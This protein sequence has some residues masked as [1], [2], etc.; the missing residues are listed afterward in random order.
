MANIEAAVKKQARQRRKG[1]PSISKEDLLG[2]VTRNVKRSLMLHFQSFYYFYI[3]DI[4]AD[5]FIWAVLTDIRDLLDDAEFENA[6]RQACREF[7]SRLNL[8][9]GSEVDQMIER[10]FVLGT[11]E[12]RH[13]AGGAIA[14]IGDG[15]PSPEGEKLLRELYASVDSESLLP[16]EIQARMTRI[17]KGV[18]P[19]HKY[20][21]FNFSV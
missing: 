21:L 5:D 7:R 17:T 18:D 19:A 11:E 8:G 16:P 1:S 14:R 3:P 4:E 10:I 12:Q 13:E 15:G 6:V 2:V 20:N 9:W